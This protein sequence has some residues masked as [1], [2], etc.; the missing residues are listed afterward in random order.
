LI[1]GSVIRSLSGLLNGL[2]L[3]NCCLSAENEQVL[4]MTNAFGSF[5]ETKEQNEL[6]TSNL[7]W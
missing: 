2:F 5:G 1:R 7:N 6:R 4:R 3:Q